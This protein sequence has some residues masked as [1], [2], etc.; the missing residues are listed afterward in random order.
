MPFHQVQ[1]SNKASDDNRL[2]SDRVDNDTERTAA[3]KQ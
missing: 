1:Y 3:K 2:I